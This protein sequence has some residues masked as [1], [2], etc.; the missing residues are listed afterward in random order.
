[1]RWILLILALLFGAPAEAN[2]YLRLDLDADQ[3]NI[4]NNTE[5]GL[6]WDCDAQD[7][8]DSSD[9]CAGNTGGQQQLTVPTGH[10][11][12]YDLVIRVR[13]DTIDG[14]ALVDRY[15]RCDFSGADELP[16]FEDNADSHAYSYDSIAAAGQ[17]DLRPFYFTNLLL[18]DGDTLDCFLYHNTGVATEDITA[19]LT[20]LWLIEQ[21][22][23]PAGDE[24]DEWVYIPLGTDETCTTATTCD[25]DWDADTDENS[26]SDTDM[27]GGLTGDQ[28]IIV[29]PAAL[30]GSW[31]IEVNFQHQPRAGS[32][33]VN[34]QAWCTLNT[35]QSFGDHSSAYRAR[36]TMTSSSDRAYTTL[37]LF[38][39]AL[40]AGDD[41]ECF[42]FQPGGSTETLEATN[43]FPGTYFKAY[44]VAD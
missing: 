37:L 43:D 40:V 42:W 6:V 2:N 29:W 9:W 33:V 35:V 11:G 4:S 31:N 27:F 23:P 26:Q 24:P 25:V 1:M 10:G 5:T 44:K 13:L 36:A 12:R 28:D 22:I 20:D 32:T 15:V 39:V 7:T 16:G 21:P 17:V 8:N 41:I 34:W 38:D 14:S 30:A 19:N 18:E 3:L